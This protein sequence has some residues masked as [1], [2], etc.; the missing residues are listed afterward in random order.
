MRAKDF[1]IEARKLSPQ[2]AEE[3][4]NLYKSGFSM[5]DI[6]KDY[7][8]TSTGIYKYL[9]KRQDY[10]QLRQANIQAR[11][12]QGLKA[13]KKGTT[14]EQV[15]QMAQ[16]FVTGEPFVAIGKQFNID[17][18]LVARYL[19]RLPN[20]AELQQQ[21]LQAR[22]KL[23][24]QNLPTGSGP[25]GITSAQVQQMAQKFA[26]GQEQRVIAK[27]YNVHYGTINYWLRQ[28]PNYN[29]LK[30]QNI[31]NR[32]KQRGQ[33]ITKRMINKPLS[34]GNQAINKSGPLVG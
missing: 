13:G 18:T 9:A 31:I 15:Q 7:Q 4:V 27:E 5:D 8:V 28:L 20:F 26:A 23:G 33:A 29:E 24:L 21:Q 6:A 34:K 17:H 25:V 10:A 3:I 30:Q 1:L 22:T 2:Q 32:R 19:R 16:M 11:A 14:P 12:S